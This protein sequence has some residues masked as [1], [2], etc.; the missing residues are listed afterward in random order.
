MLRIQNWHV[1]W[2]QH[3]FGIPRQHAKD[4]ENRRMAFDPDD[5]WKPLLL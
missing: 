1:A 4:S 3:Q 2:E 5:T